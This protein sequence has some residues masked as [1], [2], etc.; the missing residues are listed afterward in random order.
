MNMKR[1]KEHNQDIIVKEK[2]IKKFAKQMWI[3]TE[4]TQ[5]Q[6][7]N[8]RQIR[9]AFQTAIALAKWDHREDAGNDGDK[10]IL[11]ARQFEVVAKSSSLFDNYLSKMHGI[12]ESN[13]MWQTL[14]ARDFVRQND[15][16]RMP[17]ERSAPAVRTRGGRK[18]VQSSD[19]EDSE[20]DETDSDED[21]D[22]EIKELKARLKE[23]K[24]ARDRQ[25][26]RKDGTKWRRRRIVALR[27]NKTRTHLIP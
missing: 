16:V 10:P 24:R 9:N 15:V 3:D 23:K 26:K 14:A 17:T 11:S 5:T 6:R 13:D 12:E 4:S 2:E 27:K 21:E 19:E 25:P 7:W 22:D 18:K 8:G 20:E 1:V